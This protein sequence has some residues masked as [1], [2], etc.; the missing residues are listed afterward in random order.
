MLMTDKREQIEDL[1]NRFEWLKQERARHE[2][3]WKEVQ[4]LVAPSVYNW[5][6]PLDK[7]PKRPKRF[8][9]RPTHFLKTLVSGITGYSISPNIVWQK[10]GLEDT[11]VTDLYG[12]KDWLELTERL[13][14]AEFKRSNL[15]PQVGKFVEYA[16]TYGHAAMLIDE[17]RPDGRLRFMT[18]KISEVYL[19]ADEY[20]EVDT[21][22]RYFSMS[23]RNLASF[24]GEE[25]LSEA[26]KQDLKDKARWNS[27]VTVLHAVYP[28]QDFD[29]DA[30]GAWNKP[31]A[32]V[33][34]DE[35]QDHVLKE[36]GYDEFPYAVFIWD[37]IAGTAYGE[38]PA[39]HA[40]K[41]IIL[42]NKID[43][44]RIKITQMS[45]DPALNVP[46]TMR[47]RE[48]V[49]PHGYNYYMTAGE[50]ITPVAVGANYPITLEI[51]RAIEDRVKDWF[52]VDFF[53]MLQHEGGKAMTATEVMELQGEKAAV[54]SDL[55]VALNDALRQI[56]TRSFNILFRK[57]MIP[58]PPE[59]LAG[60]GTRLKVDFTGP[61]AQAQK[62]Y[63]EAGGIA[64]G[65]QIA[66]AVGQIAPA[67]LDVINFD[68]LLK[69]GLEGA[70]VSQMIINEDED[71]EKIRRARAEAQERAR[72][73]EAAM[74]QQKN[75]LGNFN[76]LNEP[77]KPGSALEE[78]GNRAGGGGL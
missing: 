43:E 55:V 59:A 75:I 21:V 20:G 47:G 58:M 49:V 7:T 16:A 27:E 57:R 38:C 72:Q 9:T 1:K 35:A 8:T 18:V 17:Y 41:D 44:S 46:D 30:P 32:S 64:Q 5:D 28:R 71:V 13:L 48:N 25:N 53:L 66:A 24:F 56:I 34:L 6:N 22:F 76:K 70:G 73:E 37:R 78:M 15:Y 36:S 11:R 62:K 40:I 51:N 39:I 4:Q 60:T 50:V 61:L 52:H 29:D 45:A 67:A 12:V 23:L 42:L 69:T 10:L 68:R 54:L 65:L 3:D 77:V 63:H 14:Y 2:T 74:E 33:Y 31:W 19:D 26:R